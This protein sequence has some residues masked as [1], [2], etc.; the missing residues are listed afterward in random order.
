M[1]ALRRNQFAVVLADWPGR[2]W[3]DMV[4]IFGVRMAPW[5]SNRYHRAAPLPPTQPA[6]P[7]HRMASAL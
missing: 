6:S 7:A 4:I 1:I 3:Q 2:L 5:T